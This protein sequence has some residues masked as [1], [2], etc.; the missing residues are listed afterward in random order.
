MKFTFRVIYIFLGKIIN[1]W[2]VFSSFFGD[3]FASLGQLFKLGELNR[4]DIKFF[5]GIFTRMGDSAFSGNI[6]FCLERIYQFRGRQ[7]FAP[8]VHSWAFLSK[9]FIQALCMLFFTNVKFHYCNVLLNYLGKG[10]CLCAPGRISELLFK[11]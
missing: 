11:H 3:L 10:S 2:G 9:C 5:R 1:C 8:L 7:I 6:F 4:G